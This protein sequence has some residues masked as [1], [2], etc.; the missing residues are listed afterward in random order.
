[1]L[2]CV[3][4]SL[5]K[6]WK[7]TVHFAVE[8][9]ALFRAGCQWRDVGYSW[10]ANKVTHEQSDSSL[11]K[12]LGQMRNEIQTSLKDLEKKFLV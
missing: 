4:Q 7:Y 12:E 5:L 6:S 10:N 8:N 9:I 1:M 3:Q 2:M 11:R